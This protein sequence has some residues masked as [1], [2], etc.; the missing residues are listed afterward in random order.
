MQLIGVDTAARSPTSSWWP[1]TAPSESA[2]HCPHRT[3]S[4]AA[5][6]TPGP[7]RRRRGVSVAELLEHT[8]VLAHGTT[9]GLNALLTGTGAE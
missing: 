7:G 9:V 2:R 1:R 5:S 4:S 8:D 3:G 6:S